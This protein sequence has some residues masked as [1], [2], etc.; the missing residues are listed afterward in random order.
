MKKLILG[1]GNEYWGNDAVGIIIAQKLKELSPD[2]DLKTG[3]FT[4]IDFLEAIEG[5]DEVVVIDSI[6]NTDLPVGRVV[7]F[8]IEDFTHHQCFSYLH[9]M[10]FAAAVV[11]GRQLNLNLPARLRLFGI[12]VDKKGAVGEDLS[13]NVKEKLNDILAT[14]KNQL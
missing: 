4:G 13:N 5:Y 6:L 14:L 1:M 8:K 10:N 2:Y 11:L 9:S 7:E 3:A 12:V